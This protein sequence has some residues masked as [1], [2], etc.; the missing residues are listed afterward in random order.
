MEAIVGAHTLSY[1]VVGHGSPTVV[2]EP[3]FGDDSSGWQPMAQRLA[4]LTSVLLYDRAAYGTSSRAQDA[5]SGADVGRDLAGVLDAAGVPRPVVLVGHSFGGVLARA[6][7]AAHDADV[8]GMV[9]VDSSTE[10]Q[11]AVLGPVSTPRMRLRR[12]MSPA[13]FVLS[14]RRSRNGADR[15]SILREWR[16]LHRLIPPYLAAGALGDRPLAVLTAAPE[17]GRWWQTWH[18]MHRDFLALS[19]N[20]THVVAQRPGHYIQRVQPD[21]VEAAIRAVV[22]S[23]R[24]GATLNIATAGPLADDEG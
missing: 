22:T 8:A 24:S 10:G 2:I 19:L 21:L 7:T 20:A 4:D 5:R 17:P 3:G 12:A 9:L 1:T 13:Q 15:R 18:G 14:S 6:Y 16:T 11:G 23:A